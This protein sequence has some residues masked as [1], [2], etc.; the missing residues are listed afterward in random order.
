MINTT[1]R[2]IANR[3]EAGL[4]SL[5]ALI[6]PLIE[7]AQDSNSLIVGYRAPRSRSRDEAI[8]YFHVCGASAGKTPI[9]A[10]IVGGW[11]GS[12]LTTPYVVMRLL[13]LMEA[14]ANLAAGLEITAFPVA[15]PQ[16]HRAAR[17]LTRQQESSGVRCWDDSPCDHVRVLEDEL[18]RY[19]YDVIVHLRE[20]PRALETEAEAW[21]CEDEH[22][23]AL[24]D[25]FRLYAVIHPEFRWK[26]NPVRPAFARVFT[27]IP[28]HYRQPSE[29]VIALSAARSATERTND[30]AGL[31]FSI[32]HTLRQARLGDTL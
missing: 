29:I 18:C 30:A 14:R 24:A 9:R 26:Q 11:H 5:D 23:R 17:F 8:P 27:P 12:E 16:A 10:L 6:T 28:G 4:T 19:Q 25:A 31:V 2:L 15:N 13:A 32:L 1:D 21:L 3:F 20:H 7:L 22:K